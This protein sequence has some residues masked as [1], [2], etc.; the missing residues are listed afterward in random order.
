ME[1]EVLTIENGIVTECKKS[2][3]NVVIP[4]GVK[5]IGFGAFKECAAFESVEIS[6]GVSL[7]GD[8]AFSWCRKLKSVSIAKSV[9]RIGDSAFNNCD[10]LEA[11]AIPENVERIGD[12]AFKNCR[13]ID[14]FALP[15]GV[16]IIGK[17]TFS[18]CSAL[19]SISLPSTLKEIGLHSFDGCG[20]VENITSASPLFPFNKDTKKLYDATK[21]SKKEILMLNATKEAAKKEKIEHVQLASA[22]AVL[23]SILQEHNI[24][25]AQ[26]TKTEKELFVAL[27]AK[28]GGVELCLPNAKVEKWMQTLSEFMDKV[29]D[30]PT[31]QELREYAK[32]KE[33]PDAG[34]KNVSYTYGGCVLRKNAAPVHLAIPEGTT[35]IGRCGFEC[36][37]SLVS[38]V[39]PEGVKTIDDYG[40]EKCSSLESIVFPKS[41]KKIGITAFKDCRKLKNIV[42][43]GTKTQWEENVYGK[44]FLLD[45]VPATVVK[46]CDGEVSI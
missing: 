20:A 45:Y 31:A 22:D 4:S 16:K 27:P 46:C 32:S 38:V 6:E 9:K 26:V 44:H 33:L 36:C 13:K 40:F 5:E 34:M 8:Y 19:K 35:E 30:F 42:Y 23:Q 28:D 43:G 24:D 1:D 18:G 7:I 14:S 37:Q 3:V 17:E 39:I 10:S 11:V 21:K 12:F 25:N 41:L 2:A 15:E 29:H